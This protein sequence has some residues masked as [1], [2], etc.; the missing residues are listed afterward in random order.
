LARWASAFLL[1]FEPGGAGNGQ[2]RAIPGAGDAGGLAVHWLS[3]NAVLGLCALYLGALLYFIARLLWGVW[4]TE[5]LC[6]QAVAFAPDAETT[7][8]LSRFQRLLGLAATDV[9]F[10][11]SPAIPGPATIGLRR[12]TLLMPPAFLRRLSP[13][14]VNAVLAHELA[15]IARRD[16]A[17]N[18]FYGIVSLPIAYHPLLALSRARL[19]ETREL[20]CD[21]MAAE[22]AGGRDVYARSLLR[23]AGAL[24][25]HPAPRVLHAIGILD[26]NIFERRVMYLTRKSL[27]IS[28][29]RR[30]ALTAVCAL[31]A[32][33]TCA[34]ALALRIDV[35]ATQ[36][37]ST[38]PGKIHVKADALTLVNK[39]TPVYPVAAKKDRV[40]GTVLLSATIAKDGTVGNLKVVKSVRADI[41]SSALEAVH[42]WTYKPFLLN[43]DPIAVDTTITVTYSFAK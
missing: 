18:L 36:P 30:I 10:A 7:A 1:H 25:D 32:L 6:R 5:R 11:A 4:A 2:V 8:R 3:A 31:L 13:D 28:A 15:H 35:K 29:S 42:Q 24:T 37:A 19:A 14:E 26:A 43:G 12:P 33:A 22:A 38:T 20:V 39:V 16:F 40:S 34:S 27:S 21:A 23:L 17:K 9:H 41:D